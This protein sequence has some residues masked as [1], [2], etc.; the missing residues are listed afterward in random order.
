MTF[1]V[2]HGDSAVLVASENHNA[3]FVIRFV[4]SVYDKQLVSVWSF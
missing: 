1:A 4:W 2:S 3:L